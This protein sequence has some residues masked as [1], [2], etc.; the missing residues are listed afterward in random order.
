MSSAISV[1]EEGKLTQEGAPEGVDGGVGDGGGGDA[2][3]ATP[4]AAVEDSGEAG[5]QDVAPVEEGGAFVEV[6]EAEDG[7]SDEQGCGAADAALE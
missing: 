7:G 3:V 6:G 4:G 1:V 2:V 5:E